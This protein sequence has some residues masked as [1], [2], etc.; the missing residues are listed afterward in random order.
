MPGAVNI[1]L[2]YCR[3]KRIDCAFLN[4]KHFF[5]V[6]LAR[7]CRHQTD[8][9]AGSLCQSK[10]RRA[11]I[12]AFGERLCLGLV[13]RYKQIYAATAIS[14]TWMLAVFTLL[15]RGSNVRSFMRALCSCD[16]LFPIEQPSI[17]AISLCS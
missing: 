15:T 4:N 8:K 9:E 5:R 12:F 7:A 2:G 14:G 1:G 10:A 13:D 17:S 6:I 3:T 11:R 16:L